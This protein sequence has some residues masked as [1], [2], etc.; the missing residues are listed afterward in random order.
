MR[1]LTL[2]RERLNRIHAIL[3]RYPL[4][5]SV[6]EFA[7]TFSV[8]AWELEQA[9]ELGFVQIVTRKPRTGRPARIVE[10]VSNT[11]PAKLPPWRVEIAPRIRYRQESFAFWSVY[12]DNGFK[13]PVR[14]NAYQRAFATARSYAGAAAS[15]SRL[16]RCRDVQ[17]ARAWH[18]ARLSHEVPDEPMPPTRQGIK[19]RLIEC[20]SWRARWL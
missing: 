13:P 10:K 20:G 17:A 19:T 12:L 11:P 4:G 18:Y 5:L 2:C 9:D 3:S 7:R 1:P 6:R 16:M 14:A 15:A 8:W